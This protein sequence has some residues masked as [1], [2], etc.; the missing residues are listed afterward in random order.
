MASEACPKTL[1]LNLTVFC[2]ARIQIHTL[3]T[4]VSFEVGGSTGSTFAQGAF[5]RSRLVALFY[6][7]ERVLSD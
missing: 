2:T 6:F 1:V 3:Y 4:L 5:Y 7:K